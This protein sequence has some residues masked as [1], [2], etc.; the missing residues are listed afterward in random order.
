M[1]AYHPDRH[2]QSLEGGTLQ[3]D[4]QEEIEKSWQEYVDQ[5]GKELADET[6]YFTDALNEILAKGQQVF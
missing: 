5:V 1:I 4:F 6:T 2:R 3:T